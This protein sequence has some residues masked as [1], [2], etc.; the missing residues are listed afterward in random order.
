MQFDK[1]N[2][3]KYEFINIEF[4]PNPAYMKNTEASN[5]LFFVYL[6]LRRAPGNH[7]LT[8]IILI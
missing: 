6:F 7:K 4:K 3:C 5:L 2:K 8:I 1:L